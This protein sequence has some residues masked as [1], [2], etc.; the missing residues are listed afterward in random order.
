MVSYRQIKINTTDF[1]SFSQLNNEN[2]PKLK[3][4][5]NLSGLLEVSLWIGPKTEYG[6]FYVNC[7]DS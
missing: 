7:I 5:H 3:N 6:K 1:D 2:S 4:C